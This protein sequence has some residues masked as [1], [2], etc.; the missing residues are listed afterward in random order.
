GE[1]ANGEVIVDAVGEPMALAQESRH[2]SLCH[3]HGLFRGGPHDQEAHAT[4]ELTAEEFPLSGGD[5]DQDGVVLVLAVQPLPLRRATAPTV[6][7]SSRASASATV[8]VGTL[9]VPSRTPLAVGEPASTT[10]RSP[11]ME[12]M[13][14]STRSRAPCPMASIMMTAPTPMVTPSMVRNVRRRFAPS[15]CRA[16]P[17]M[18]PIIMTVAAPP[19]GAARGRHAPPDRP[20]GA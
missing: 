1:V 5:R 17:S 15:A 14:R 13:D 2:V 9:P 12:A 20:P 19:C 11:P 4:L 18:G 16:S 8:S 6:D 7:S 3:G 10:K